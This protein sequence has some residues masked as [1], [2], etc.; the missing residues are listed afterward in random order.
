MQAFLAARKGA[1]KRRNSPSS[2]LS[3][4]GS[5]SHSI[6]SSSSAPSS[7]ARQGSDAASVPNYA[8]VQAA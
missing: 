3:L 2:V 1:S 8:E 5:R 6:G 4:A 7:S